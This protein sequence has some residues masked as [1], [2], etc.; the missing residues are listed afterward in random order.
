MLLLHCRMHGSMHEA[1]QQC[2]VCRQASCAVVS[3]LQPW[4][5]HIVCSWKLLQV[6]MAPPHPQQPNWQLHAACMAPSNDA[7]RHERQQTH[8]PHVLTHG[9]MQHAFDLRPHALNLGLRPLASYFGLRPH[10]FGLMPLAR[11]FICHMHVYV[12]SR[13][14]HL[15][16]GSLHV[17][18]G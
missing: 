3:P 13:D 2:C 8:M 17:H 7:C 9:L 11:A 18:L 12:S 15:Y 14:M 6:R 5:F 16:M 1:L 10:A 4:Q